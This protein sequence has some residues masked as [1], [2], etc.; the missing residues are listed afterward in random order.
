MELSE[1]WVT[2]RGDKEV[3]EILLLVVEALIKWDFVDHGK[4]FE[5]YSE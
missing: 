4:D 2:H 3:V 1:G 5:F